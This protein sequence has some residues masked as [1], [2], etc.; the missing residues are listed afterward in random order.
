MFQNRG[1]KGGRQNN[2]AFPVVETRQK[3][4]SKCDGACDLLNVVN[5]YNILVGERVE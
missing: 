5:E 3:S 2:A 4:Y 1:S